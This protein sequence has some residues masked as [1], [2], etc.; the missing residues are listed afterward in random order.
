MDP[1]IVHPW[2]NGGPESVVQWQPASI[3]WCEPNYVV[4]PLVAEFWNTVTSVAMA[5]VAAYAF[6]WKRRQGLE[7]RF[8]VTELAVVVI[9]LG[10]AL[11]HGTLTFYGQLAD[12]LP[13]LYGAFVWVYV[14]LHHTQPRGVTN[15]WIV[16][17]LTA[18]A[19]GWTLI[20][21]AVHMHLNVVF[22]LV[23][24]AI[25]VTC[26]ALFL[27]LTLR[28][29]SPHALML[30]K[31]YVAF[32]IISFAVWNLVRLSPSSRTLS[33]SVSISVYDFRS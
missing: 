5:L 17:G 23:F 4:S 24:G 22:E 18:L 3:D 26:M 9:G 13:M 33:P 19:L 31:L 14:I 1:Q 2:F 7:T 29:R 6:Y 12:E 25:I 11:F 16:L 20:S 10:S 30:F 28:S 21:R 27:R 8:L 32:N 15:R